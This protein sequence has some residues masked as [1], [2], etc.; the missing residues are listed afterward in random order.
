MEW[1]EIVLIITSTI[2]TIALALISAIFGYK[3][4]KPKT[5]KT[6]K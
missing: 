2:E 3:H 6:K 5:K 4:K 1:L